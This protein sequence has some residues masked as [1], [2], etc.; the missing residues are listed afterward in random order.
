M[1]VGHPFFFYFPHNLIGLIFRVKIY[2]SPWNKLQDSI[3]YK[4]KTRELRRFSLKQPSFDLYNKDWNLQDIPTS[5]DYLPVLFYVIVLF[6]IKKIIQHRNQIEH[7][8]LSFLY[9]FPLLYFDVFLGR[10]S[11][12]HVKRSL[13]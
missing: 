9:C 2:F 3:H 10:S 13:E 4:K 7:I 11:P 5:L 12:F 1:F 8:L 6:L